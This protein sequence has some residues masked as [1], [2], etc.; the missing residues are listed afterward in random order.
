MQV[1]FIFAKAQIV[2]FSYNQQQNQ[3]YCLIQNLNPFIQNL[4]TFLARL[5]CRFI[6]TK[7]YHCSVGLNRLYLI[8]K[9]SF[10]PLKSLE[11]LRFK[12]WS[13]LAKC[14]FQ[15]LSVELLVQNLCFFSFSYLVSSFFFNDQN[16][17]PFSM[18]FV[19]K[20]NLTF[21]LRSIPVFLCFGLW[22]P[23]LLCHQK[24]FLSYYFQFACSVNL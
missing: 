21:L 19:L 8:R 2:H 24:A 15:F 10:Y 4:M 5:N 6:L 22:L 14:Y 17:K 11:H 1:L 16:W 9:E 3:A 13:F 20:S 7:I 18:T 23:T 12:S